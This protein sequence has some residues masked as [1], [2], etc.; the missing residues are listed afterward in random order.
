MTQRKPP[1]DVFWQAIRQLTGLDEA[2]LARF[3]AASRHPYECRCE[4][5]REWWRLV[6]PEE[7]ED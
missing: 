4:L 2:Q 3:E 5:C 6:P 1:P 7:D